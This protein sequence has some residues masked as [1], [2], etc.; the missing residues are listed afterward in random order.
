M[1]ISRVGTWAVV[2]AGATFAAEAGDRPDLRPGLWETTTVSQ[3]AGGPAIDLS[4]VPPQ[5]RAQVEA[6][7]GQVMG[8]APHTTVDRSCMTEEDMKQDPM[9]E[10]SDDDCT[11]TVI[12]KTSTVQHYKV[13]CAGEHPS[14][15]EVKFNVLSPTLVKGTMTMKQMG[16][17]T[18]FTINVTTTSK[19]LAATCGDVK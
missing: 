19:W 17:A 6:M 3:S 9:S 11:H 15:G 7:M 4:K 13:Q 16:G 14:T 2:L 1:R 18:P 10:F 8:G 5:Q 12:S